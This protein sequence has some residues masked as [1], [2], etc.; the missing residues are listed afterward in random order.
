MRRS[1]MA[2]LRHCTMVG[3][4]H[5]AIRSIVQGRK[6]FA[7]NNNSMHRPHATA[8][9]PRLVAL[10]Y[11]AQSIGVEQEHVTPTQEQVMIPLVPTAQHPADS[12]AG[13]NF[14]AMMRGVFSSWIAHHQRLADLGIVVE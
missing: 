12:F 3:Q 2:S 13:W 11:E 7:N 10:R 4:A 6:Y 14:A 5:K 1:V 8:D 9:L